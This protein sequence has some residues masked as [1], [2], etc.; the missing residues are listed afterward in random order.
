VA[1]RWKKYFEAHTMRHD[2]D[3]L[4]DLVVRYVKEETV[5]PVKDL[6]RYAGFGCLGSIFIGLGTLLGLIGVLRLLQTETGAFH[7]NLSWLPYLIVI[8][9]ALVVMALVGWRIVA[10][11]AKRRLPKSDKEEQ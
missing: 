8:A 2:V 11:P 10:G 7:G 6:G 3:R 5:D 9:L 4:R 1:S